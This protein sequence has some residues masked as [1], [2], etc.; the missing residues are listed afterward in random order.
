MLL[1]LISL[2]VLIVFTIAATL[3]QKNS[4]LTTLE[5]GENHIT[6]TGAKGVSDALKKNRTLTSLSIPGHPLSDYRI[7]DAGAIALAEVLRVNTVLVRLNLFQN[8]I[9]DSGAE[10][11]AEAIRV[12]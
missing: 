8:Y 9:Q 10:F 2:F 1:C 11:M 5:L 3:D 4:T 7:R 6:D 12:R